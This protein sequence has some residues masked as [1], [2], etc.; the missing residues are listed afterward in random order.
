[1][2]SNS[3]AVSSP[4][5]ITYD[6][7]RGLSRPKPLL[8]GW[9]HLVW[10]EVSLVLGTALLLVDGGHRPITAVYVVAVS[11]LFGT[12]ALYHRGHWDPPAQRLL[13]RLD[14]AM[15]FVAIAGT[16][17]PLFLLAVPGTAGT[18][19][20]IGL[21]TATAF[22]LVTHMVWMQAPEALVGSA[23]V[24]LGS[25]G[26]AALPGVWMH[27]GVAA[28]VLLL[29]GG[30]LYIVGA[31]AYHRRW[32]DPHPAVFGFH[33]VFHS[34]VCVAATLQYIAIALFII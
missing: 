34:F 31:V 28:F 18:V 26:A 4:P 33:E 22:V 25:L 32:P 11:A 30:I 27:A 15:I 7:H 16:A 24:V 1:M 10:F 21:L 3:A 23:Y 14:H 13:E 12:S 29:A 6:T 8:R 2:T 17:T 19:M 5:R 9:M 20:L